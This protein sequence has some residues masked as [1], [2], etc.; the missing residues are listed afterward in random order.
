MFYKTKIYY[1]FVLFIPIIGFSQSLT[2]TT[3]EI[4]DKMPMEEW[5]VLSDNNLSIQ[6]VN[7]LHGFLKDLHALYVADSGKVRITQIGDSHTQVGIFQGIARK[8][9]QSIFGNAGLGFTF[10][11]RLAGSNGISELRYTSSIPWESKRNIHASEKDLVG[12]SGFSLQTSKR[13]F[14]IRLEV[15]DEDYT[16]NTLRVFTPNASPMFSVAQSN[17][18]IQLKNYRMQRKVHTIKSGEA[19]SII[20]MNY[21]VSVAS[22][23]KVNNLR[24]DNSRAGATLI[25]PVKINKPEPIDRTAFDFLEYLVNENSFVYNLPDYQKSIWLLPNEQIDSFALNGIVLE[26]NNPGLIYDGIGVNGARFADYNKTEL[27]FTQLK[28]LKPNLL[29]IS[30]GTNEAFDELKKEEYIE[31]LELFLNKVREQLPKVSI[32]FTTPPPSL[33]IRRAPN[34]FAEEYANEINRLTEKYN[35]AVW[36]LYQV[37]GGNEKIK[38]NFSNDLV[39]R[40]YIHYTKTGYELSGA[41]FSEALL[42]AYFKYFTNFRN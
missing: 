36:D 29:V 12:L 24:S 13:D 10:P 11:H 6:N 26:R 3:Y 14:A 41:L 17:R 21:G 33:V 39:A 42:E 1:Y 20:G 30:L 19:L 40:D 2:E 25:I 4:A 28:E 35:V 38:K 23:K 7:A 9:L 15:S 8:E 18:E 16:F 32:L 27:F 34:N 22:I 5:R 37:L 31:S